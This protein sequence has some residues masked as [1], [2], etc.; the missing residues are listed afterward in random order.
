MWSFILQQ[1]KTILQS[2]LLVSSIDFANNDSGYV[3][4]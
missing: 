4:K 3:I 1:G 2:L